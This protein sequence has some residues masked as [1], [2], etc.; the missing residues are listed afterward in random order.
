MSECIIEYGSLNL[1][2][3][4][5]SNRDVKKDIKFIE[6]VYDDTTEDLDKLGCSQLVYNLIKESKKTNKKKG[7]VVYMLGKLFNY[8]VSVSEK[9]GS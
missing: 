2:I 5:F 4:S 6:N 7:T 3:S 9:R 8:S 1:N